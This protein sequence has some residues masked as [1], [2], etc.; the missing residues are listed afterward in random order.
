MSNITYMTTARAQ[1]NHVSVVHE[2]ISEVA[3]FAVQSEGCQEYRVLRSD[4]HPLTTISYEVWASDKARNE[5]LKSQDV[6]KFAEAVNGKFSSPP[7]Q[8]KYTAL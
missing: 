2:A 8:V 4:E 1:A 7:Q 3:K 6:K 5:F